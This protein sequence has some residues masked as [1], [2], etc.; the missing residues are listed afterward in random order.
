MLQCQILVMREE[1]NKIE[2]AQDVKAK[3]LLKLPPAGHN[4]WSVPIPLDD[5]SP[6]EQRPEPPISS[7]KAG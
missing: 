1:G 6:D 7:D 5:Q 3:D 2:A 4:N